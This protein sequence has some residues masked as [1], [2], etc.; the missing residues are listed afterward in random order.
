MENSKNPVVARMTITFHGSKRKV[1]VEVHSDASFQKFYIWYSQLGRGNKTQIST[2]HRGYGISRHW[3]QA[4]DA[5]SLEV[6]GDHYASMRKDVKSIVIKVFQKREY[7]R[8]LNCAPD[9]LYGGLPK[10]ADTPALIEQ[11]RAA[12]RG[13]SMRVPFGYLT[14]QKRMD[15]LTGGK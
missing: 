10:A 15:I 12:R 6:V 9:E 14:L 13:T 4:F 3:R 8:L 1:F 2:S 5:P 7:N 11:A